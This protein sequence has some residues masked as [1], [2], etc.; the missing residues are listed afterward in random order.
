M[1]VSRAE[2]LATQYG[3]RRSNTA[4]SVLRSP[5]PA[6]LPSLK[7]GDSKVLNSWVHETKESKAVIFNQAW[8]PGVEE[9]DMLRVTASTGMND[10]KQQDDGG[11]LFIVPKEEVCPKPQ[12]QVR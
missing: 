4:T 1:T 11:F 6:P 12:L 3:R 9:G 5:A 2:S 7:I 8:W 10:E